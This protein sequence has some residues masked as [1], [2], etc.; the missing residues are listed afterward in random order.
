MIAKVGKRSFSN[1]KSAALN[2][3]SYAGVS[4]YESRFWQVH[5]EFVIT[6]LSRT[7]EGRLHETPHFSFGA[8][9]LKKTCEVFPTVLVG[10]L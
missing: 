6:A 5:Q 4:L 10:G 8:K 7:R 3:L 2:Q 1:Y 9:F